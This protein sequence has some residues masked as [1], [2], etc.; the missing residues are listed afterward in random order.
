ML[1]ERVSLNLVDSGGNAGRLG[2]GIDE[3][4]REVG[5]TD[6]LD[7]LRVEEL[8]HSLPGIDDGRVG[9]DLARVVLFGEEVLGEVSLC[10][11]RNGPVDLRKRKRRVRP[12]F[13]RERNES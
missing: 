6:R 4:G 10:D 12:E 1:E 7:L 13:E 9:V 2:D 3:L 5:N 8:D 11:E